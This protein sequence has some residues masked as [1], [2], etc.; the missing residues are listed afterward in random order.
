MT[1]RDMPPGEIVLPERIE[2]HGVLFIVVTH[3]QVLAGAVIASILPAGQ[4]K[5]APKDA[6]KRFHA[7]LEG[8]WCVED[9]TVPVARLVASGEARAVGVP[10]DLVNAVRGTLDRVKVEYQAH[11][12]AERT[13]RLGAQDAIRA[14]MQEAL[15]FQNEPTNPKR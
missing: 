4:P 9:L 1:T 14:M 10:I 12:E 7:H 3:H 6:P 5:D 11:V 2:A 15:A 8:G 13:R